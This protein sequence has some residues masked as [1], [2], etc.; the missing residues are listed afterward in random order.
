MAFIDRLT[1]AFRW[2][3]GVPAAPQPG[4]SASPARSRF[5]RGGA[6]F[7]LALIAPP[8]PAQEFAFEV[9]EKVE[10]IPVAGTGMVVTHYRPQGPGPF[11]LVIINHGRAGNP[12][13]RARMRRQ[14]FP[15][16]AGY[17]LRRGFAVVV[18]TRVGY[19]ETG[20]PDLE[21]H[22]STGRPAYGA[23]LDGALASIMPALAWARSLPHVGPQR[24]IA[25]GTSMGGVSSLA[26]AAR[27]PPEL[28]AVINFAGGNGGNP[29]DRPGEPSAPYALA[30]RYAAFGRTATVPS[31]WLYAEND[32][33]WGREFPVEWHRAYVAAGGRAELRML[34]PFERD[35]H[36]I[37]AR[38]VD[39][40]QPH[41]DDFLR[42]HA[43]LPPDASG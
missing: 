5:S 37:F 33:Y 15:E 8:V 43:L 22:G 16:P 17:F 26:L 21:H 13:T 6:A 2:L 32:R 1:R 40:W 18:P 14:R 12:V 10:R 20:G 41:V 23:A 29:R 4:T 42:T 30:A 24:V 7:L 3:R 19:G 25:V 36:F 35:G 11:P 9:E 38:A 27:N 34:P 28:A 39:L 31:L